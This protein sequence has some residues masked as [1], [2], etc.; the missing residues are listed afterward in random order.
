MVVTSMDYNIVTEQEK[1]Q[2][3]KPSD[4]ETYAGFYIHK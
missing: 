2:D 4:L 1:F 3:F